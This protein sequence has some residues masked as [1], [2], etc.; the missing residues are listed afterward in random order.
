[1]INKLTAKTTTEIKKPTIDLSP[2]FLNSISNCDEYFH[3]L[4]T[5]TKLEW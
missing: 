3:L 1:M 5:M 2:N 4:Q